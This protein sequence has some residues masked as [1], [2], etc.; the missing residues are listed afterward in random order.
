MGGVCGQ[1]EGVT[2]SRGMIISMEEAAKVTSTYYIRFLLLWA[3]RPGTL[4]PQM[5]PWLSFQV[6]I[7]FDLSPEARILLS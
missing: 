5:P 4:Q 2:G 3:G 1:I 6:G 7:S